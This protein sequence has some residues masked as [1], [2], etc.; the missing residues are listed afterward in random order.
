MRTIGKSM[1]V[2]ALVLLPM[3]CLLEITGGLGRPFGVSDLLVALIFAAVCF[4]AGRLIEGYAS[5]R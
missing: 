5:Q 1:Q 3:A 4:M 2:L